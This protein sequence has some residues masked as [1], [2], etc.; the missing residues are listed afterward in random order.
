MQ[1]LISNSLLPSVSY[2]LPH[3]HPSD[4]NKIYK[5]WNT[6]LHIYY[7]QKT[8]NIVQENNIELY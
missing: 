8:N 5:S 2:L 3:L 1:K 6:W 7:H 4:E